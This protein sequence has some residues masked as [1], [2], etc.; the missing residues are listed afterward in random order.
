MWGSAARSRPPRR[1]G[2]CRKSRGRRRAGGLRPGRERQIGCRSVISMLR[3]RAARPVGCK[4]LLSMQCAA[5]QALAEGF[6]RR[7]MGGRAGGGPPPPAAGGTFQLGPGRRCLARIAPS[8]TQT[9]R[10]DADGHAC[11]QGRGRTWFWDGV[12]LGEPVRPPDTQCAPVAPGKSPKA[13]LCSLSP[14]KVAAMSIGWGGGGVH[15]D[16]AAKLARAAGVRCVWST[17]AGRKTGREQNAEPCVMLIAR[18][19]RERLGARVS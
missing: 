18:A 14:L 1:R 7:C 8:D 19:W 11:T 5:M 6:W 10:P 16:W 4:A 12:S 15:E 9:W 17:C 3:V 13:H 2:T